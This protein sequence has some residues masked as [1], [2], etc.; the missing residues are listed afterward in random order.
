[1]S[2]SKAVINKG[3]KHVLEPKTVHAGYIVDERGNE[4]QITS[5]M[6]R[7]VCHQLL[8]QCRTVKS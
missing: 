2:I 4:V 7:T 6:I 5:S 1:M 3:L 8:K